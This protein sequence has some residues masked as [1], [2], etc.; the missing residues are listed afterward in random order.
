MSRLL[1]AVIFD[2]DGV[3]ADTVSLYYE[4][5]K[6]LAIE[7]Q[8]PFTKEDNIR[9]QGI[10]RKVLIDELASRGNFSLTEEEKI[11]LGNKKGEY[12]K[13]LIA[14]FSDKQML[15]GI[16][17][18]LSDLKNAGIKMAIASSSSNAPFLLE[19][20]GIKEWFNCIVDPHSLEKGK[21]DPEIFLTA[22]DCL[23]IDY[24]NCAAIEDGEAGLKG[25]METP[26][27][28]V[29]VGKE[30]YLKH[31]DWHVKE[32]QNLNL[33]SLLKKFQIKDK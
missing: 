23:Q 20:F 8:V 10:P 13:E 31:A 16:K 3:I 29:G 28:S 32:T 2:F 14:D 9:F 30:E 7:M 26:M 15:P 1:K 12:Y 6:R 5:T 11:M 17:G 21:P 18:F 19:R 33:D 25:I 27:F 4:A 24:K 22:A